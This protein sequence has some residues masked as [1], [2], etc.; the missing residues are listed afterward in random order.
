MVNRSVAQIFRTAPTIII[1]QEERKSKCY[2]FTAPNCL[3]L[4][5]STTA[6]PQL[7]A[8]SECRRFI[9]IVIVIVIVSFVAKCCVKCTAKII[10]TTF[11]K[12]GQSGGA[13]Y[14]PSS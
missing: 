1:R 8:K 4:C 13:Y 10:R 6:L 2:C 12:H 7:T 11:R 14:A 3:Y 5:V 9:V